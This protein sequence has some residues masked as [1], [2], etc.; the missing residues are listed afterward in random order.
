MKKTIDKILGMKDEEINDFLGFDL[1]KR[2]SKNLK[3]PI[4]KMVE[5]FIKIG[6]EIKERE[7][8]KEEEGYY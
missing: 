7:I 3:K 8:E 4:K 2:L 5:E 1:Q 6:Y